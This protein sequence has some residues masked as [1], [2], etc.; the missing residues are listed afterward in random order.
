M[1]LINGNQPNANNNQAR[2]D[3]KTGEVVFE[4]MAI[5]GFM[6]TRRILIDRETGLVRYVDLIRNTGNAEQ[7][8]QL[9]VQTNLN[10]GVN[11]QQLIADPKQKDQNLAWVAQTG[12]GPVGRRGVRGQG[13][14][15]RAAHQLPAGQQLRAG[16]PPGDDRRRQGNRVRACTPPRRARTR[17]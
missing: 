7:T 14:E 6:V 2:I 13:V 16:E 10:Y 12:G 15:A 8:V 4:N 3:E 1:L 9:Q 5:A 17:A 11:A